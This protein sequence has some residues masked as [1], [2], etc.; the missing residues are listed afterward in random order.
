MSEDQLSS[1]VRNWTTV[2]GLLMVIVP[3]LIGGVVA[4]LLGLGACSAC[5]SA[6]VGCALIASEE[7]E[8]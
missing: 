1:A 8:E 7:P 2:I 4:V 6:C 3:L 5:T